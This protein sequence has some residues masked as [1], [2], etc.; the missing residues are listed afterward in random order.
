[1][2]KKCASSS[3]WAL[4]RAHSS[5]SSDGS[6]YQSLGETPYTTTEDSDRPP[7]S[8]PG[9]R[10]P[11]L[12]IPHPVSFMTE[13]P[14]ERMRERERDERE[15]STPRSAASAEAPESISTIRRFPA[16][17]RG[18]PNVSSP[19]GTGSPRPLREVGNSSSIS[20]ISSTQSQSF[21]DTISSRMDSIRLSPT[22]TPS[23][24]R[25]L[26]H[27][28]QLPT[29]TIPDSDS[30]GGDTTDTAT[31]LEDDTIFDSPI[32]R[33]NSGFTR[34]NATSFSSLGSQ[35]QSK[36][37]ADLTD[38]KGSSS[39]SAVSNPAKPPKSRSSKASASYPTLLLDHVKSQSQSPSLVTENNPGSARAGKE[40]RSPV[41][42]TQSK[43]SSSTSPALASAYRKFTPP[44]RPKNPD[45]FSQPTYLV[46][47]PKPQAPPLP[48]SISEPQAPKPALPPEATLSDADVKAFLQRPLATDLEACIISHDPVAQAKLDALQIAWG[49]QFQLARGES[50]GLWTWEEVIA[51][52]D[53]LKGSNKDVGPQV[54]KI[55]LGKEASSATDARV[56]AEL[57]REQAA[58]IENIG[59]GEGLM[60]EWDGVPDWHGGQVQQLARL[61]EEKRGKFKLV[62]EPFENRRSHR[63]ARKLSSRRVIQ[64]R[65][66]KTLLEDSAISDKIKAYL[67]Q[68]FVLL[69][70]TYIPFHVKDGSVYMIEGNQDYE[71]QP[72]EWCGDQHRLS[73]VEFMEWHNPMA[74]NMKQAISKF[75][76]RYALGLSNT[77][78]V[79]LFEKENIIFIDDIYSEDWPK[80]K[81]GAPAEKIMTDGCGFINLA[82]L[83]IIT[84]RMGY[85]SAP[86]AL[87]G[88]F[89]GSKG[90]WVRHPTDTSATPRIWIRA[91]QNKIKNPTLDRAHRIFELVGP[92]RAS[93][94]IA[95]S[96]QSILNM[97]FNG[98]PSETI[99]KLFNEGLRN[100]VDP[101]LQWHSMALLYNSVNKAGGVSSAR[102]ARIA[103]GASRVLGLTGAEW[104]AE[105]VEE[106][107]EEEEEEPL[108]YTGRNP[109]SGAP[110]SIHELVLELIQAGFRPEES[111][112]MQFKLKMIIETLVKTAVEKYRIPLLDSIAAWII[113][114]PSANEN[115]PQG[116][117]KEN[118]IYFRSSQ[119]MKDRD[120][121][122]AY[123]VITGEV[124]VGR[125]PMR[126][127]S[128]LQR[129]FAVDIAEFAQYTDVIIVSV[130]GKTSLPSLLSGGDM[131]GD[132]VNVFR[133]PE[134]VRHFS[135]KPL[136]VSTKDWTEAFVKK[137]E[138]V[139]S[140]CSRTA[141]MSPADAMRAYEVH[142]LADLV[143]PQKGLYSMF[144]D[145]AVAKIGYSHEDTVRLAYIFNALLDASKT[146]LRLR[147]GVFEE[148]QKKYGSKPEPMGIL[149]DLQAEGEAI[150]KEFMV[151][152]D[153]AV[154]AGLKGRNPDRLIDRDLQKPY[155]DALQLAQTLY[156][157]QRE[158]RD[159][160]D[161]A[162]F[163]PKDDPV[164]KQIEVLQ[165]EGYAGQL[166]DEELRGIR[167]HVNA[168]R[169]EFVKKF[170]TMKAREQH[171]Q[172][173]GTP[174][175]SKAKKKGGSKNKSDQMDEMLQ[176][177]KTYSSDLAV[178]PRFFS[179]N[180]EEIKASYAY[181]QEVEN[182][183]KGAF[184]WSV[185]F[186]GLCTIKAKACGIA[187]SI[188][189][190]DE[191]KTVS[192]SAVK[193][194]AKTL[195]PETV[196]F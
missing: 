146:G 60:G 156:A 90:L 166:L 79:V 69:G 163:K 183:P 12:R 40:R 105:D 94:N 117:L 43:P 77:V 174:S 165:G 85:E 132:I 113:P 109:Y 185:A 75:V 16:R 44:T 47:S 157:K 161:R 103:G 87:Q 45:A 38:S 195:G 68:R 84:R 11:P 126:L 58:I 173:F 184:P 155:Q 142:I 167:A 175:K 32:P 74:L 186:R 56:W 21:V 18:T 93:S 55:M 139:H 106:V 130:R 95:L 152:F 57:D 91:S 54:A 50:N 148:D 172:L 52:A 137:V 51:K 182:K 31:D 112:T 6:D 145:N 154:N 121:E 114:D 162:R 187:P 136:T 108:T 61:K 147:P 8:T 89:D 67:A 14:S 168:A 143:S 131:D 134:I 176:A 76:T 72:Q 138:S 70:R 97:H 64:I 28:D 83:T 39:T 128:D 81:P 192:S 135:N 66:P 5:T 53:R 29:V 86:T 179:S 13:S 116:L 149:K 127:A 17:Q 190:I 65:V 26:R 125:Y 102:A 191:C 111:Y 129:V 118:E 151:R 92:S 3:G 104:R 123:H 96:T 133:D 188:R 10:L 153:E 24:V 101:L 48:R 189:E 25:P 150:H 119:P 158:A 73:F 194:L 15:H 1:M 41:S 88:R 122:L 20:S 124:V 196:V 144:H 19:G 180:F 80:G 193:V 30:D 33:Q 99:I 171:E 2:S 98:V 36:S 62:L 107:E 46:E 141:S 169:D 140:F 49:V 160:T 4:L 71:R 177:A 27:R 100:L 23:I 42:E 82:A 59:R 110:L 164:F 22:K 34:S 37:I 120:S 159:L 9:K 63:F 115:N 35:S 181:C 78:P 178:A 7:N 170:G